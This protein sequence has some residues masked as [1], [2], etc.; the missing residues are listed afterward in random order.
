MNKVKKRVNLSICTCPHYS[1]SYVS[2]FKKKFPQWEHVND[3][4]YLNDCRI[5]GGK[6]Y[7]GSVIWDTE[8]NGKHGVLT[9]D[10]LKALNIPDEII[11]QIEFEE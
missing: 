7:N 9:I 1:K 5:S 2:S 10:I 3:A 11:N 8:L 6:D 4:V